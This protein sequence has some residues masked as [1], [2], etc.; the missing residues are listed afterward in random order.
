MPPIAPGAHDA[1]IDHGE[2]AANIAADDMAA[3][4][5]AEADQEM[6]RAEPTPESL[7]AEPSDFDELCMKVI[8]AGDMT[9]V[10]DDKVKD[11]VRFEVAV[12][13][14]YA[15]ENPHIIGGAGIG[16][17]WRLQQA[18]LAQQA[19]PADAAVLDVADHLFVD[20]VW[21][22]DA[23]GPIGGME[24]SYRGAGHSHGNLEDEIED[25]SGGDDE[26][27]ETG[28]GSLSGGS[29]RSLMIDDSEEDDQGGRGGQGGEGGFGPAFRSLSLAASA[30][31]DL[32]PLKT[33]L[34]EILK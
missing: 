8:K 14:V 29:L 13:L 30:L 12:A 26:I 15:K 23:G 25:E 20:G 7:S 28:G 34:K 5:A 6:E 3:H 16:H 18:Q 9:S 17:P 33:A 10:I 31:D 21:S 19:H 27:D 1:D 32:S 22:E 24:W 4:I 2:I 11:E